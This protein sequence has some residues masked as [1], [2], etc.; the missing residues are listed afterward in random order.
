MTSYLEESGL[1]DLMQYGF[2]KCNSTETA[3]IKLIDYL[4]IRIDKKMVPFLLLSD[5]SKAFDGFTPSGG[6]GLTYRTEHSVFF[7][8]LL[9]QTI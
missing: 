7:W 8:V 6:L 5:F 1:L 3:L 2:R 4:R 9:G